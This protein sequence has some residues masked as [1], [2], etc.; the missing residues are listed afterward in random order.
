[1]RRLRTLA[2]A[3][4]IIIAPAASLTDFDQVRW[5]R[6]RIEQGATALVESGA[7]YLTPAEF[8]VQ[9]SLMGSEFGI[10]VLNPVRLWQKTG[11]FDGVPYVDFS[12]PS[13]ARIR[14]FS[15]TVP[16]AA[17]DA[18]SV[19]TQRGKVVG[20]R[21]RLGDGRL[22]FLGSPAGPHLLIAD[23]EAQHWFESFWE[24]AIRS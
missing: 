5:L 6:K 21:R 23:P 17:D 7:A 9:K 4:L 15:H 13:P 24:G 19:A 22:I 3:S 11:P 12:W 16:L 14:D 1:M 2:L 8:Q 10:T 18:E 20:I